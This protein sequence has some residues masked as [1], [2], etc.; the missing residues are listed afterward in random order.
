MST[1]V[2]GSG[3][4]TTT[5]TVKGVMGVSLTATATVVG[6]SSVNST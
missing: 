6:S 3:K 2:S 1:S 4:A 5:A